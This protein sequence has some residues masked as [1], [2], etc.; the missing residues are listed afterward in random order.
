M[1][2][3]ILRSGESRSE[4]IPELQIIT[5]EQYDRVAKCRTQHRTLCEGPTAYRAEKVDVVVEALLRNIFARFFVLDT[6]GTIWYTV[7]QKLK[8][9]EGHTRSA[10]MK[11][12]LMHKEIPVVDIELDESTG[13]VQKL[14][15]VY[16]VEHL[17]LGTADKRGIIDRRALNMWWIDRCIPASRSGIQRAL[18]VLEIA[19]PQLL[20][21]RCFGL[22]LSDQ[23]W[24][25]PV[26]SGLEWEKINF[27]NNPFSEDI[28][29]VLL[30]KA[31]KTT[32]F[33]FRSPD[34]TSDG[35]LK[36]AGKSLMGS[37]V[38]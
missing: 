34:N 22:S 30:G 28:G 12:T 25:K 1:Y 20:L 10:I 29:D 15:A 32:G 4:I 16:C 3:G 23:Y 8:L 5:Q 24:V 2:V 7:F 37:G 11:Y 38:C 35:F 21:S 26:D 18:E 17:P 13:A 33:D 27:F 9:T 19:A 36:N 14:G 31:N 6:E